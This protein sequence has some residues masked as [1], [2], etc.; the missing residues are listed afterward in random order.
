MKTRIIAS[1]LVIF[2]V[3]VL[4]FISESDTKQGTS[5]QTHPTNNESALKALSL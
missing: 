2:V 5:T 4:L 1:I 3:G